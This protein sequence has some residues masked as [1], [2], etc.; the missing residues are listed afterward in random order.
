VNL[1]EEE[2]MGLG[3]FL[4]KAG[5]AIVNVASVVELGYPI[6]GRLM[7]KGAQEYVTPAVNDLEQ[8]AGVVTSVEAISAGLPTKLTGA[9]KFAAALPLVTKA[10]AGASV[11]AGK[12]IANQT[13][14]QQAAQEYAQATVDLL[15]SLDPDSVVV[16]PLT[17]AK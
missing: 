9:Q 4:K 5:E 6:F 14:F 7:P 8:I 15:N 13:L 2:N 10:I 17:P 12:K 16:T 1:E 3:G 11:L